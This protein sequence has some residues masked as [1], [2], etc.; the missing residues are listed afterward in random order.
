MTGQPPFA[1]RCPVI[2]LPATMSAD[3][4]PLDDRTE[5]LLA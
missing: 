5:T 2:R 3:R 1:V 4:R